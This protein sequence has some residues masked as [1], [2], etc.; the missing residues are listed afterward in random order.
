MD[1][2]DLSA[3]A[4][5][6]LKVIWSAAEWGEPPI[7][8][9]GLASRFSTTAA[10]VSETLRRLQANGL[11]EYQPYRPAILTPLGR[12]LA[13]A[14]VRRHRLLEVFLFQSLGFGWGE[15]HA[16]AERLEHAV[17]GEFVRR[18]D[19]LVGYPS[20]DPHGD[21]IPNED[22]VWVPGPA[23]STLPEVAPGTYRIVRVS[24]AD[25]SALADLALRGFVPGAEVVVDRRVATASGGSLPLDSVEAGAVRVGRPDD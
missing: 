17:S 19:R 16:E 8:T 5:D 7:T 12:D 14:M 25:S 18:I 24:D 13:I 9:T 21:P 20:V 2:D 22:G 10:N 6:Y 4:Q 15:V 23:T 11:V 1:V 3:V